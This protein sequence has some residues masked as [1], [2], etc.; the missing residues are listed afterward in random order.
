MGTVNGNLPNTNRRLQSICLLNIML[1][2]RTYLEFKFIFLKIKAIIPVFSEQ[3]IQQFDALILNLAGNN[4]RTI[5]G[6]VSSLKIGNQ[7]LAV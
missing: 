7:L 3:F 2:P 6:L 5:L 1:L 4:N